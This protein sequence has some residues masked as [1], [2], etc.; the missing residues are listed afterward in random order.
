MKKI[1]EI[2]K[3]YLTLILGALLFLVY[4][5]W[6]SYK[7]EALAIGIIAVIIS[8]YY[9]AVGIVGIVVGD[10][11]P[12]GAKKAFDIA[13]ICLFPVFMFV[14][15]LLM[16]ING[17]EGMKPTAWVIIILSMVSALAF[18]GLFVFSRLAPSKLL[19]RLAQLFAAVFALALLLNL[20]FAMDGSQTSIDDIPLVTLIIYIVY[21]YMAFLS[22]GKEEAPKQVEEKKEEPAQE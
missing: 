9:L 2:I 15:W 16:T 4:L 8:V 12:I 20:L 13:S 6:L 14:Y 17:A 5:N 1:S 21:S 7:G 18:A 22:L 19:A 11:L 3:P 10:K